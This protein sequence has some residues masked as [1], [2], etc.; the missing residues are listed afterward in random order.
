MVHVRTKIDRIAPS[1]VK[2]FTSIG[3]ATVHEAMGRRGAVDPRIKPAAPSMRV[4]GPAFT[5]RCHPGDNIMLLKALEAAQPGDVIVADMGKPD[6][7]CWGEMASSAGKAR[8]LG[9]LVM[10]ASIRDWA[11]VR[12]IGFPVFS[13]GVCVKGTVKASLGTINHPIVCGGVAV[14]PGDLVIGDEDGVV[15]VP[16]EEAE[17]TLKAAQAREAKEA[18]QL[19]RINKGESIFKLAGLDEVWKRLGGTT[20]ED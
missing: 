6:E 11:L 13:I 10:N 14:N 3:T 18:A 9:G 4:C 5:V 8:R 19:E 20:D 7:G 17:A 1:F 2:A 16:K 12:E 15:V